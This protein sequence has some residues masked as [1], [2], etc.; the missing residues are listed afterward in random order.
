VT[1]WRILPR[2]L[3]TAA[4]LAL[5]SVPGA[6]PRA[7][8]APDPPTNRV[9]V[10]D[11]LQRE[12]T[13]AHPARRIVSLLPSLTETVCALGACERLLATDRYSDW[14]PEVQALPKTGGLDDAQIEQIV[15]LQP[16]VVL[17]SRSQRLTNRLH[18]L[19]VQSF[20]LD[21][22]TYP[23]IAHVVTSVGAI[24]ALP[25][26]AALLNR[27]IEDAVREIGAQASARRHGAGPLVYAEI[28]GAPYAAGP[29]SFIGELLAMLGARNILTADLGPFPKVNPEYVVRHDPEVIFVLHTDTPPLAERPGWDRIRAVREQR[30]CSYA[31]AVRYTIIRPGPRIADGMRAM[32]DCLER[33]SP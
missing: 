30:L 11:D 19:G 5:M 26:R 20:A 33:L 25:E 3:A 29:Q 23:A 6:S 31:Q 14:P 13:L 24:L 7:A 2:A 32:E 27:Q 9:V 28:D 15:R 1:R 21:T 17:L 18:E 4:I 16:D 10:R 22:E 8:Q 12:V